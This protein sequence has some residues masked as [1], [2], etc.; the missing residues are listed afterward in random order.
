E[1]GTRYQAHVTRSHNCNV[2]EGEYK[3]SPVCF[4]FAVYFILLLCGMDNPR[5]EIDLVY[6]WVD[7]S[8]PN[9]QAKKRRFTGGL[10]DNS[11]TNNKG[12]YVNN[13]ELRYALRSAEKYAP[14]IRRIFIVT[15]D[16]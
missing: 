6:L 5:S 16:Q 2:H 14:W 7:G 12:R 9:W 1:T 10:S 8:D 13:D 15:D 11:E 3:N 4:T